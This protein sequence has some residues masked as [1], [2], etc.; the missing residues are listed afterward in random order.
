MRKNKKSFPLLILSFIITL[1]LYPQF[2]YSATKVVDKSKIGITQS[3]GIAL[4]KMNFNSIPGQPAKGIAEIENVSNK[5]KTANFEITILAK[6]NKTPVFKLYSS[7]KGLAPSKRAFIT[8][9]SLKEP[10]PT[11]RNFIFSFRTFNLKS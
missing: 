2:A 7:V 9:K 6:D 10:L 11:D 1:P 8:F 4:I 3:E 5:V